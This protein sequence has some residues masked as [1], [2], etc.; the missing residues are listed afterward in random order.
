VQPS[1]AATLISISL[2]TALLAAC[3]GSYNRAAAEKRIDVEVT[4]RSSPSA[5]ARTCL[6]T[7]VKSYP[8][9]EVKTLDKAL[10]AG[11][12]TDPMVKKATDDLLE[13]RRPEITKSIIAKLTEDETDGGPKF[14]DSDKTCLTGKLD[15]TPAATL[16]PLLKDMANDEPTTDPGKAFELNIYEC[17]QG[18]IGAFLANEVSAGLTEQFGRE[19]SA[20]ERTCITATVRKLTPLELKAA[21]SEGGDKPSTPEGDA[22]QLAVLTCALPTL[23]NAIADEI[24]AKDPLTTDERACVVATLQKV[25]P[26]DLL[27]LSNDEPPSAELERSLARCIRSAY[28]NLLLA[29]IEKNIGKPLTDAYRACVTTAVRS[30][31]QPEYEVISN[32]PESPRADPVYD[33]IDAAC[34]AA[35]A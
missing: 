7:K 17:A 5:D 31:P 32:S 34:P 18:T 4:K 27:S 15:A 25:T 35:A 30:L 28:T 23:S 26:K 8:V 24:S 2:A 3:G 9:A 22:L 6:G 21:I 16:E 20:D 12:D 10:A 33:K 1:R 14:A 13:C 11:T 19:V 29:Q